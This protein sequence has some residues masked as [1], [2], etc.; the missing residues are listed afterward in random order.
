MFGS[1]GSEGSEGIASA[2]SMLSMYLTLVWQPLVQMSW[3]N[4]VKC[5]LNLS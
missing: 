4:T 3:K 5:S 1:E 2:K